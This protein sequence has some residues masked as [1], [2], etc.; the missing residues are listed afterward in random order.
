MEG[1]LDDS[2]LD[3]SFEEAESP[4]AP[5]VAQPPSRTV[6]LSSSTDAKLW[7][8]DFV[9]GAVPSPCEGL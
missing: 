1:S 4:E 2:F 6:R 5:P 7:K 8:Q 3:D 9:I